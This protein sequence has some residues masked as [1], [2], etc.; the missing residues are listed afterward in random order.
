MTLTTRVRVL[1][2]AGIVAMAVPAFAAVQAKQAQQSSPPPAQAAPPPPAPVHAAPPSAPPAVHAAPTPPPQ[3]HQPT[4]PAPANVAV[5]R[6]T[7]IVAASGG[8]N[9]SGPSRGGSGGHASGGSHGTSTSRGGTSGGSTSGAGAT[10]HAVTRGETH[11]RTDLRTASVA[12]TSGER[13]RGDRTA[14]GTAVPR[15]GPPPHGGGGSGYPIYIPGYFPGY[16]YP[17]A[18]GVVWDPFWWG[19]YSDPM[20]YYS[21]YGYP[22][23]G[24]PTTGAGGADTAS[25]A[26]TTSSEESYGY[27]SLKLKIKPS[28]AQVYVDGY[29]TGLVD[30]FDGMFQ[31]LN[32]EV[33]VHHIEIRSEGYATLAFDVRIELDQT[34]TYK[35]ELQKLP[36]QN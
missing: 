13:G 25:S 20:G 31:K 33:G 12:G 9:A 7:P 30:D 14:I 3:V 1:A 4:A 22:A 2:A 16:F 8:A 28:D 19:G 17:Y 15:T 29:F 5:P 35:A 34:V 11:G 18:F 36:Q 26:D 6:S 24:Y 10:T 23:Y 27:G 21:A 32:L